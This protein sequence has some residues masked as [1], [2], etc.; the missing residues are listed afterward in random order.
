MFDGADLSATHLGIDDF[1]RTRISSVTSAT[2][3]IGYTWQPNW[4]LYVKGG[5]GWVHDRETKI[6]LVTGLPEG[7]ATF[8][9][10]GWVV[11]GGS[12]YILPST[13]WSIFIDYSY[14]GL[15]TRTVNYTNLEVPPVPPTFPLVIRQNVQ[16]LL[17]GI[18]Y[19]FGMR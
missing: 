5:G 6:D 19:R 12:E 2:G 10:S 1:F 4:L 17:G 13:N 8:T 11:G 18:N 16:V 14:I 7:T 15:G 3:R 9:R